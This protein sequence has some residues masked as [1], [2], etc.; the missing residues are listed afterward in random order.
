VPITISPPNPF[1]VS[2]KKIE[3]TSPSKADLL[4][5]GALDLPSYSRKILNSIKKSL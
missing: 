3:I 2:K 5:I 4:I 1:K